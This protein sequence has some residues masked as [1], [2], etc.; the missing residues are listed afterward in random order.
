LEGILPYAL[1][2]VFTLLF[3]GVTLFL[4]RQVCAP[5]VDC[6]PP[7]FAL[8]IFALPLPLLSYLALVYS[9]SGESRRFN[10]L[11]YLTLEVFALIF[12]GIAV[13]LWLQAYLWYAFV[14]DLTFIAVFM[15]MLLLHLAVFRSLSAPKAPPAAPRPADAPAAPNAPPANDNGAVGF[16]GGWL[17]WMGNGETHRGTL[18]ILVLIFWTILYWNWPSPVQTL[19]PALSISIWGLLTIF[20]LIIIRQLFFKQTNLPSQEV[21]AGDQKKSK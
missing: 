13:W 2:G 9:P 21:S 3:W 19:P 17:R 8:T 15:L 6:S 11:T 18:V 4:W 7:N 10:A 1:V 20:G 16:F 14:A 5:A 12:W